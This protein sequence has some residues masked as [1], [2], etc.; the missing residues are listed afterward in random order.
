MTDATLLDLTPLIPH[1]REARARLRLRELGIIRSTSPK[2]RLTPT[3]SAFSKGQLLESRKLAEELFRR[4][5]VTPTLPEGE[6]AQKKKLALP[7][8]KRPKGNT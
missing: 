1:K 7:P 6:I 8:N 3:T 4:M 5:R 2:E